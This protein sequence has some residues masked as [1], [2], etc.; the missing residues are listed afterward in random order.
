MTHA[1]KL[2]RPAVLMFGDDRRTHNLMSL[3]CMLAIA[4]I[5]ITQQLLLLQLVLLQ[6]RL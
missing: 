2:C 5:V 3:V 1:G 4:V 6:L